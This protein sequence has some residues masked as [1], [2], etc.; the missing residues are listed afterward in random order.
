MVLSASSCYIILFDDDIFICNIWFTHP[1]PHFCHINLDQIITR[2]CR[3][4]TVNQEKLI[5]IDGRAE[6]ERTVSQKEREKKK[7]TY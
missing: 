6:H 4:L 1:L 7:R 5:R 3:E 2:W